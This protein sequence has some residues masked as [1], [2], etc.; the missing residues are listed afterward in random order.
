MSR[1]ECKG[2]VNGEGEGVCMRR[3]VTLTQCFDSLEET[4]NQ[5]EVNNHQRE[6]EVSRF[7]GGENSQSCHYWQRAILHGLN[8][9]Q[10][11]SLLVCIFVV[12]F[13]SRYLYLCLCLSWSLYI[14]SLFISLFLSSWEEI[15]IY[16]F[17]GQVRDGAEESLEWNSTSERK[18][19]TGRRGYTWFSI[20]FHWN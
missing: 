2:V 17:F 19:S 1:G 11:M 7:A 5:R 15:Y 8:C 4:C 12:V 3:K 6:V 18:A 14:S 13:V 20:M 16:S 10:R 9:S